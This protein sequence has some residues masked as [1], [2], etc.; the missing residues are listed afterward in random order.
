MGNMA[1]VKA[2]YTKN[3]QGAK[4]SI[5][6]IEHRPGKDGE[7]INRT[8]FNSDGLIGRY[9]AYRMI[10]AATK[11]SVFFRFVISPDPKSEDTGKDLFLREITEQTMMSL[12]NRLNTRLQWVAAEH[13]DHAPHRHIHV[14]AVVPER[15]QVQDFHTMRQTATAAALEQR[16][17][18]DLAQQH[19]AQQ[20]EAQWER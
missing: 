6:Y 9:Q 5:R 3:R 18:H 4:A 10:D 15:L 7:K 11:G 17:H 20:R 14:V 12:E 1:I 13:D 16:R 19:Q 8:L 2:T